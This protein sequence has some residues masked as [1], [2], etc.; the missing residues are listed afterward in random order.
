MR[1]YLASLVIIIFFITKGTLQKLS[2]TDIAFYFVYGLFAIG[3]AFL[4]YSIS[5]SL[6]STAM[7]V[8]L[9]YTGPTFVNIINRF[10]YKKAITKIKVVAIILTLA[11]CF[12]VIRGYDLNNFKSNIWGI[13]I[14]LLS[15]ICYSFVTVLG[16]K[17]K[18]RFDGKTNAGLIIIFGSIVFIFLEPP[19]QIAMPSVEQWLF[20]IALAII[21]T[22]IPYAL[23]LSGMDCGIEGGT[24]SI[25]ATLEPLVAII[26]G[27]LIFNEK[28]EVLQIMGIGIVLI[29][30]ILPILGERAQQLFDRNKKVTISNK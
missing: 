17:A 13:V 29:G 8:M 27:T 10:V 9:L 25:I 19:W 2:I 20:Y 23:Y 15:G 22:I 30:I 11:G 4:F 5:M 18:Q 12:L 16:E 7:A 14:G 3:G 24:A 28:I 6:L 26:L 21:V 1:C